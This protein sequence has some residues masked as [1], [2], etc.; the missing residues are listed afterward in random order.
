MNTQTNTGK[1]IKRGLESQNAQVKLGIDPHARDVVVSMQ[2][3]GSVS[4]RAQ[5]P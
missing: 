4:Q 5:K 3:N 1:Q 2:A